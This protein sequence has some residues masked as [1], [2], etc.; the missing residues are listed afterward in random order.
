MIS[1]LTDID[2]YRLLNGLSIRSMG[3]GRPMTKGI[4]G[5]TIAYHQVC[6]VGV[7]KD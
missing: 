7:R 5:P 2:I 3:K 6:L 1:I 4:V